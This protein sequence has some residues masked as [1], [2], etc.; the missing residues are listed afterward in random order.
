MKRVSLIIPV[1][2]AAKYLPQMAESLLGQDWENLQILFSDDGSTDESVQILTRLAERDRRITVVIEENG[3]VSAARNRAL[4][5]ADGDYIGFTDADDILKPD[6][7]CRLAEALEQTGADMACCG[8]DRIYA[9]SGKQDYLPTGHSEPETVDRNGMARLLLRPDGYTTVVWN[10]LFRREALTGADG[11]LMRFDESLHIVEDGEYIFRSGVKQAVFFPDRLYCYY[12]RNSGAMYGKLT[13]RKLTE[14]AAR[15]KIV[16]L[17]DSLSPDVQALA[18]MKYQKGVRDLMFHSVIA[19]DGDA[20]KHLRS[21]LRVYRD[22]LFRS[23][24]L[25][26]KEK[27]KYHIYGPIIQL[28]LRHVGAFLMNQFGGH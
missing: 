23:P 11:K 7:V 28:N 18:K 21:E 24:A 22:E 27:I 4:A 3:G 5:L 15:K 9:A 1:Y 10:K 20:V 26:K 2:N 6:Y 19:G 17:T 12:V 13:D 14:L 25:T 16:E 8:F